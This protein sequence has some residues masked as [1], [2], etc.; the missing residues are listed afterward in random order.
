MENNN[1][2]YAENFRDPAEH[3][4]NTQGKR[5]TQKKFLSATNG[6]PDLTARERCV[7][8][9]PNF[10]TG[11]AATDET[12][13]QQQ[14][15]AVDPDQI[16]GLVQFQHFLA[17]HLVH[18][19]IH[20]P[21]VLLRLGA[22][23]VE[24]Q[25][26]IHIRNMVHHWPQ[27]LLA[28]DVVELKVHVLADVHCVTVELGERKTHV[29]FL[30]GWNRGILVPHTADPAG[31]RI[32]LQR[33]QVLLVPLSLPVAAAVSAQQHGQKVGHDDAPV[34]GVDLCVSVAA[35]VPIRVNF[36][37]LLL[38][39]NKNKRMDTLCACTVDQI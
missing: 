2:Y 23:V 33:Q 7:E 19:G 22:D 15:E 26:T 10:R 27:L 1:D 21:Q 29:F 9:V 31:A 20:K 3:K 32:E 8:K 37:F 16:L 24:I 39:E 17:K 36:R 11:N 28:V 35:A 38:K 18:G 5:L 13:Q 12:R 25:R 30:F 14:V 34:R 4:H 6:P